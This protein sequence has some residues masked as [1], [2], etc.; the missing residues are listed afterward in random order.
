MSMSGRRSGTVGC[1]LK[2]LRCS[3]VPAASVESGQ[4]MRSSL[5]TDRVR[6]MRRPRQ[7]A[8]HQ[9]AV[10]HGRQ[11]LLRD[12]AVRRHPDHSQLRVHRA[13]YDAALLGSHT[14]YQQPSTP[15]KRPLSTK[16]H[17]PT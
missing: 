1:Q 8:H 5:C 4:R 11:V 17:R 15:V 10:A 12:G 2:L 7:E 16:M 3:V 6:R 9:I 13:H 14:A